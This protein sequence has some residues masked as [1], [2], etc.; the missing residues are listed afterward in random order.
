[1]R[2]YRTVFSREAMEFAVQADA[3]VFG[4]IEAWV[5]RVERVPAARGDYTE[6]DD[7]GRELQ[8]VILDAAVITY[9]ADDAVREVRVVRIKSL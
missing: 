6:R 4:E 7:D 2:F 9:W 5:N 8:V 1:M 3:A